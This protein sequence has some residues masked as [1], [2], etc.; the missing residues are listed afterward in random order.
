MFKFVSENFV[1]KPGHTASVKYVLILMSCII[2][3]FCKSFH[4]RQRG[5]EVI[6]ALILLSIRGQ[7]L[8]GHY[9]QGLFGSC[10]ILVRSWQNIF[11]MLASFRNTKNDVIHPVFVI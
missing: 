11:R 3:V 10:I 2:S 5:P 6:A 8:K 9:I 4:T 7:R 1:R